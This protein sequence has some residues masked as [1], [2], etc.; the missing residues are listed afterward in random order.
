[1]AT[2]TAPAASATR[3][4]FKSIHS[5]SIGRYRLKGCGNNSDG[6]TVR[7]S[8]QNIAVGD[9]ATQMLK[10]REVRGAAFPHTAARELVMSGRVSDALASMD[11]AGANVPV[12]L[13]TYDEQYCGLEMLLILFSQIHCRRAAAVGTISARVM[14]C[15]AYSW[16]PPSWIPR[17]GWPGTAVPPHSQCLSH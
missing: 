5:R 3:H 17:A 15:G 8:V 11:A 10:I 7:T 6:F 1:M 2:G 14:H 4:M 12:A 16:R 9:G 13:M